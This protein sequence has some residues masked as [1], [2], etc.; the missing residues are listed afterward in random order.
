ML[1]CGACCE[2]V[3][4]VRLNLPHSSRQV[5]T[6]AEV[7]IALFPMIHGL[8]GSRIRLGRVTRSLAGGNTAVDAPISPIKKPRIT[9]ITEEFHRWIVTICKIRVKS[10]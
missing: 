7:I 3:N 2:G 5:N 4:V 8:A 1:A 6:L 10:V 9:R